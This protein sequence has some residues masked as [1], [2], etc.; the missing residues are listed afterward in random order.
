M[1]VHKKFQPNRSSCLAG[2]RQHIYNV[3]ILYKL[4]INCLCFE[5]YNPIVQVVGVL[6][7]YPAQESDNSYSDYDLKVKNKQ[8]SLN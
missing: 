6:R 1:S 5:Y 8:I 4:Y 3:G 7:S 2:Y